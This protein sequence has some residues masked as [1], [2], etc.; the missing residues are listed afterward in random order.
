MAQ[1]MPDWLKFPLVLMVV[2]LI[3]AASL[4]GLWALT[5]ESRKSIE[6]KE[7]Q[8]ALKIVFPSADS[9][10]VK[11]QKVDGQRITYRVAKKGQSKIGYVAEGT[12][13]GY[14]STIKVLVGVDPNFVIQGIK[15]LAQKETPGLGDKIT[16]VLSKKTWGTV[17]T[18][19]SPDETNLRPWFQVQFDGKKAPVK[20]D[21]DGGE[22][23]AV[24][25]ATISSRAVCD[26]VNQAVEHLKKAVGI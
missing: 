13:T 16:E 17:I 2:A 9:F 26:A 7:T 14:S 11:E 1:K 20:V 23:E 12:A 5:Q 3:S 10:E 21:K 4:A 8:A 15:V 25:G 6:N 19:S 22:I 18:G 24:T